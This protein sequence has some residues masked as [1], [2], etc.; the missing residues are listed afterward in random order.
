MKR[1]LIVVIAV[2]GLSAALSSC[3]SHE[4]CPA[5]G[6]LEHEQVEQNS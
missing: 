5:Y 6:Q 4:T 3:K 2:A 1:I